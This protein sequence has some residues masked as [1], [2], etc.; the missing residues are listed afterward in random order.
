MDLEATGALSVA[1][2]QT[3]LGAFVNQLGAAGIA[4]YAV[5]IGGIIATI[6][7]ARKKAKQQIQALSGPLAGV[8]SGGGGS[9]TSVQAPAFNVV[10]ATQTSQLAQTIAGAEDKPLRA[11]VVASDVST[12]QELERSTIEGASIG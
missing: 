2:G 7:S 11:Y 12:A 3:S 4:A 8:S 10:G 9:S 5:S 6:V 1:K